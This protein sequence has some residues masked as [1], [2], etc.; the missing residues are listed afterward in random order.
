[1]IS[2][3]SSYGLT[4]TCFFFRFDIIV[5]KLG[6]LGQNMHFVNIPP[7]KF[8]AYIRDLAVG[9]SLRINISPPR[10][11][12]KVVSTLSPLSV[13][14]VLEI[15]FFPFLGTILCYL[16]WVVVLSFP[17]SLEERKIIQCLS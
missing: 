6:Q 11:V 3:R 10:G 4:D 12:L 5:G 17:P 7:P 8:V 9:K 14:T 2:K 16:N 13:I 15:C 1:M